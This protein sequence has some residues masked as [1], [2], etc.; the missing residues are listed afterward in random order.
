MQVTSDGD[1]VPDWSPV[2]GHARRDSSMPIDLKQLLD[3]RHTRRPGHGVPGRHRRRRRRFG[4]LGEAVQRHGTIGHIGRVLDAARAA[5]GAGLLPDRRAAR[6]FAAART[7]NCLLLALGRKGDA[8]AAGLASSRRW[9]TRS[10]R[11]TA[12][13]SSPASTA[14]R[15]FHGT[16]LDQL[17]RNLGVRTV[18]ATGVSVN[19]GITGLTIEAVNCGYQVVIPREAVTGTPDEYVDAVFDAHAAPAGD[20]DD[21]RASHA[22]VDVKRLEMVFARVL[23]ARQEDAAR[24]TDH[25]HEHAHEPRVTVTPQS[26]WRWT[27]RSQAVLSHASSQRGRGQLPRL[28]TAPRVRD[29]GLR[30]A[31]AHP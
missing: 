7:A 5:H 27:E 3:P 13:T 17:L 16:E 12:T 18:V 23:V 31:H 6:R 10:R 19:V 9:S 1:R 30:V 26:R 29:R 25:E 11:A 28:S 21:R 14:S 24:C 2:T 8:A 22:G 20:G 15:P 4:A